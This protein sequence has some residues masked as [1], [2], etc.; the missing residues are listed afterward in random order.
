MELKAPER[1][2]V[3]LGVFA[4]DRLSGG[5]VAMHRAGFGPNARVLDGARGSLVG[6]LGRSGLR[7]TLGP[8]D[9]NAETALVVVVAPGRG[10]IVAELMERAGARSV[11]VAD[12]GAT[13]TEGRQEDV[14]EVVSPP[15]VT[16]AGVQATDGGRPPAETTATMQDAG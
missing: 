16:G 14:A 5:L 8:E 4:R 7:L 9:D 3:V 13:G 1:D 6:Q 12:R 15:V 2:G 10:P 11:R